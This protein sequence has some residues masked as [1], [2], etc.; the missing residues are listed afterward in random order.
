MTLDQAHAEM[1]AI[2]ARL[3]AAYPAENARVGAGVRP[4]RELTTRNIKPMLLI[5]MSTVGMLL[6][7]ACANV[8]NLLLARSAGRRRE[9]G[10]RLAVGAGRVRLV[11][12]LLAESL[13]IAFAGGILGIAVAAWGIPLLAAMLER[14]ST[15]TVPRASTISVDMTVLAFTTFVSIAAGLIFGLVPAMRASRV[16]LNEALKDAARGS[17]SGSRGR[18]RNALVVAEVALSLMLLAGAGLA[19]PQ[20]PSPHRRRAGLQ[21]S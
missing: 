1:S 15:F 16:D 21:S 3:A 6:L 4:L 13:A 11:R 19:P 8:A 5:L 18:L 14:A 12:L 17:A 7:I 9:I 20:L 2:A 10:V